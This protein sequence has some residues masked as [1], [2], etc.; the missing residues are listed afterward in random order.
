MFAKGRRERALPLWK[1]TVSA[2][3]AW[4]AVRGDPQTTELFLNNKGEPLTRWGFKYILRKHVEAAAEHCPSLRDKRI[5]PHLLRH[6][7][8]IM[9]LQATQD[10][11]KVSLWLG[12]AS[13]QTTEIYTRVDPSEKIEAINKVT[14]PSLRKGRFRPPDR[15]M[16]ALTATT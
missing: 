11:R 1:E 12:H 9:I 8:A 16:A 10:I 14:P 3:R 4:L 2:L 7:C 5:S 15:L 6:S 13:V